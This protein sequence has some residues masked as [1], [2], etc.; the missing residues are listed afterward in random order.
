MELRLDVI[1]YDKLVNEN[2]DAG[3]I[4]CSRGPQVPHPWLKATST[5]HT[6]LYLL[7]VKFQGALLQTVNF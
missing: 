3:H 1:L 5:W 7:L 4:K 2:S 6:A